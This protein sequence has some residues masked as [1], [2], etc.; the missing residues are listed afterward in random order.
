MVSLDAFRDSLARPAPPDG[1]TPAQQALWWAG[2]G[3][4]DRAHRCAQDEPDDADADWVHAH[5]HRVERDL[6]NAGYWYRRAGRPIADGPVA[7]EWTTIAHALLA[8]PAG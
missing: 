4:W 6:P 3:D 7:A 5:L 1:L 2:K 8:E